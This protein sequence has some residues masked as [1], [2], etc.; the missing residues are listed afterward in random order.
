MAKKEVS[1]VNDGQHVIRIVKEISECGCF[2]T[3]HVIMPRELVNKRIRKR[4]GHNKLIRLGK[5]SGWTIK[6]DP[7]LAFAE[8]I[9]Q[10]NTGHCFA[11]EPYFRFKKKNRKFVV[12]YQRGGFDV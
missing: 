1:T 2:W 12:M 11:G 10:E 7:M 8:F 5:Y 6:L 4:K 3:R 9:V